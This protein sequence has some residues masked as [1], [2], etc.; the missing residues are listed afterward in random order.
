MGAFGITIVDGKKERDNL[1]AIIK[2]YKLDL[3]VDNLLIVHNNCGINAV[4]K[5]LFYHYDYF[6]LEKLIEA[7]KKF[8]LKMSSRVCNIGMSVEDIVKITSLLSKEYY[9]DM[10]YSSHIRDLRGKIFETGHKGIAALKFT[11][12]NASH[13]LYF[14]HQYYASDL[15]RL[16][17]DYPSLDGVGQVIV[18]RKSDDMSVLKNTFSSQCN[19]ELCD[20]CCRKDFCW[21]I[22]PQAPKE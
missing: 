15:D 13:W 8:F 17:R 10:R 3:S 6:F 5:L 14:D 1:S 7:D 11:G 21:E 4:S 18:F 22:A 9:P 12:N 16:K 2:K 19:R 20:I